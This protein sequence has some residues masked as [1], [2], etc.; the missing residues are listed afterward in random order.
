MVES[1]RRI[2][3]ESASTVGSS[4]FADVAANLRAAKSF[5]AYYISAKAD[6]VLLV[7][8][9]IVVWSVL[10]VAAALI[11]VTVVVVATF[12]LCA[13]IVGGLEQLF[14]RFAWIAPLLFGLVVLLTAAVGGFIFLRRITGGSKERLVTAYERRQR[15]QRSEFGTDVDRE[16]A[17]HGVN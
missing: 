9:S 15:Q 13:G 14:G 11:G 17:K 5:L 7:V 16:S 2:A 8:K 4:S 6:R 3:A 10:G 12:Y 1:D